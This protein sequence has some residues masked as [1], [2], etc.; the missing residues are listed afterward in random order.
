MRLGIVAQNDAGRMGYALWLNLYTGYFSEAPYDIC[1]WES[2]K[3]G[4]AIAGG[5]LAPGKANGATVQVQADT[6]RNELRFKITDG[7]GGRAPWQVAI[8]RKKPVPLPATFAPIARIGKHG[9]AVELLKVQCYLPGGVIREQLTAP[10]LG[11]IVPELE[12][13]LSLPDPSLGDHELAAARDKLEQAKIVQGLAEKGDGCPF[14]FLDA[15]ALRDS[16]SELPLLLPM[17]ELLRNHPQ[18]FH[19]EMLTLDDACTRTLAFDHVAVSHRWDEPSEPD[20]SGMQLAAMRSYLRDRPHVSRVWID[21]CCM[22]QNTGTEVDIRTAEERQL[23]ALM[24]RNVNLLYLGVNVL[25]LTDRSY[26]SRFW[27]N[28]EAWLAMQDVSMHGLVTASS[29]TLRSRCTIMCVHGAPEALIESLIEE[30]SDCT[31]A[32]AYQKLSAPDVR[33]TNQS[34]K[35]VQLPKILLLDKRVAAVALR[36]GIDR[37][38]SPCKF[39]QQRAASWQPEDFPALE[40]RKTF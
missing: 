28:F 14:L 5:R 36:K 19:T 38:P 24:L 31:A 35:D 20:P 26:L 30:W 6:L 40:R 21:Y 9:D 18:W 12:R 32:K 4:E 37:T 15:A 22:P 34:D 25:I 11:V 27:T 23:F 29:V 16:E 2:G 17:Q 39:G 3:A 13:A 7:E 1:E 33:A 8:I 10:P